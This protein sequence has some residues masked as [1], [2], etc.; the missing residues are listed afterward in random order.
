[1]GAFRTAVR[2]SHALWGGRYNPI[3]V[4]EDEEEAAQLLDAFNVDTIFRIGNSEQLK[5]FSKLFSYLIKPWLSDDEI[6]V[7]GGWGETAS[8]VLDIHNLLV[9]VQH[10]PE[11]KATKE[12]DDNSSAN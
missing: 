6:F 8:Q 5:A 7:S 3:V 10:T 12:Q 11:W 1:M 4:I 9:H 2:Y